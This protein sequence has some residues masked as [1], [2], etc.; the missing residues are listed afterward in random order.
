MPTLK[1]REVLK[2][3][4]DDGWILVRPGPHRQYHHPVKRGTV[5]VAG[6][7]SDD[8]DRGTLRA[9]FPQAGLTWPP[10]RTPKHGGPR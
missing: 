6:A 7:R 5:T 3:L 2:M 8:L 9:V 10:Y 4:E 1:V